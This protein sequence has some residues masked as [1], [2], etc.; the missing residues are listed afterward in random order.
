MPGLPTPITTTDALLLAVHTELVGLRADLSTSRGGGTA[1]PDAEGH[2]LLS[3]P[4]V[5]RAG[6]RSGK[7]QSTKPSRISS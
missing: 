3:E 1:E 4:D 2:V 7:R 6:V 5:G